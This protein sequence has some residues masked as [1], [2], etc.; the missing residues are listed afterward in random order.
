MNKTTLCLALCVCALLG[1]LAWSFVRVSDLEMQIADLQTRLNRPQPPGPSPAEAKRVEELERKV[2]ALTTEND[3]L[4][5]AA[6][7]PPRVPPVA[8]PSVPS[9]EIRAELTAL[10]EENAALKTKLAQGESKPKPDEKKADKPEQAAREE[11]QKQFSRVLEVGKELSEDVAKELDLAPHQV[12]SINKALAA[13]DEN[14]RTSLRD[15]IEA[16]YPEDNKPEYATADAPTMIM[17]LMPKI[18]PDAMKLSTLSVEDQVKLM[19]GD[20]DM[21]D[22]VG[23]DSAFYRLARTLHDS[24]RITQSE[25][26]RGVT[27]AI[28]KRFE[29]EFLP[30]GLYV[31]KGPLHFSFGRIKD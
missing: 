16:N 23:A 17:A 30:S 3:G 14:L 4:K 9:P 28:A 25:I 6:S 27:P 7:A 11:A 21:R 19:K 18:M 12:F 24:R 1:L 22:V 31:F 2:S 26:A 8:V 15:F 13:E 5:A 10:R 29:D 20:L